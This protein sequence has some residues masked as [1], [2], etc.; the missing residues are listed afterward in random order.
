M[1]PCAGDI[2]KC[3]A[4]SWGYV[5]AYAPQFMDEFQQY[6]DAPGSQN[7]AFLD[8]CLI[9]GSTNG[10]IDGLTNSQAFQ[11]W[12]AGSKNWWVAECANG[13]VVPKGTGSTLTGPCDTSSA[14]QKFPPPTRA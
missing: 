9:H 3:D 1:L 2:L 8:A 10:P 14:C 4:T 13:K 11:A 7:G 5:Q 6:I 12:L